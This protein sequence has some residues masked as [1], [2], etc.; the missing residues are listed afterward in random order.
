MTG[1]LQA[2]VGEIDRMRQPLR[3]GHVLV[4]LRHM[5]IV[6]WRVPEAALK[7]QLPETL[8][9]VV[10]LG[11]GFVSAVLFQNHALRPALVGVPRL[12][13]FQMNMRTYVIDPQTGAYGS[14]FFQGLYL[15][16]AWLARMSS[17]FFGVPFR[18][19]PF[20]IGVKHEGNRLANWE[21]CSSDRSLAIRAHE[22]DT[23]IDLHTLD[24]L[25]NPHTGYLQNRRGSLRRWRIWHRPQLVHP[26][27]LD[28]ATVTCLAPL[29]VGLPTSA[30]YIESVDYEVYLPPSAAS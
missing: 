10:E 21:A 13:S 11:N 29:N 2:P 16:R 9:P 24:L 23:D 8:K 5:L 18:Y 25:T 26:V 19:L 12:N 6:T 15:S 7:R 28:C 27:Q 20:T 3:P 4:T 17:L 14:V 22:V 30:L 1:G